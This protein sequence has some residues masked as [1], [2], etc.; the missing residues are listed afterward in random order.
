MGINIVT[1]FE[2]ITYIDISTLLFVCPFLIGR[3][4][5]IRGGD[6]KFEPGHM[7]LWSQLTGKITQRR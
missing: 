3:K 4:W 7:E 1:K 2:G 6:K 5:E